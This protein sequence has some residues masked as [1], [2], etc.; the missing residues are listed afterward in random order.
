MEAR[1]ELPRGMYPG[2]LDDKGRL[3]VP[4][5]FQRYYD[6]ILE[7]TLFVTSLDGRIARVYTMDA[8]R[9]TE[10]LL[11]DSDNAAAAV[12]SFTA[13]KFGSE[14]QMDVQGR[15]LF[16]SDLRRELKLENTELH[17]FKYRNHVEVVPDAIYQELNLRYS[18][19]ELL[20][21]RVVAEHKT[22]ISHAAA[23]AR[24]DARGAAVVGCS[25]R[26]LV[27]GCHRRPRR[28]YRRDC[29]AV[30]HG[31]GY[32]QRSRCQ[33]SRASEGEHAGVCG[34]DTVSL[35]FV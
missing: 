12:V 31:K 26:R 6:S 29:G 14:V 25:A 9:A 4:A 3:K 32:R 27:F 16:N 34:S 2:R 19:R 8:W 13:N 1:I 7:R 28:S 17:L 21:L 33:F 22:P 23:C 18:G 35:R 5:P 15:I 11:D 10:N 20:A 24:D 30:D